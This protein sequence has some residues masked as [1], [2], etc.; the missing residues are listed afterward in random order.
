MR[1]P[2]SIATSDGFKG[3]GEERPPPPPIDGMHLKTGENFAR[4]CTIFA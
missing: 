3:A 2:I 4:K 1:L